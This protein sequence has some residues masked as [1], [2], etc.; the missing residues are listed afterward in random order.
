LETAQLVI[1]RGHSIRDATE[2]M[3]TGKLTIDKWIRQLSAERNGISPPG[4]PMTSDQLR[5]RELEKKL[6]RAEEEKTTKG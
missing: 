3:G 5:V 1:N 2:A 4:T 6:R